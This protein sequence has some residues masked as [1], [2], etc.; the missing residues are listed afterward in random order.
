LQGIT[1]NNERF[2]G[3][4]FHVGT[5]RAPLSDRV[6]LKT[7]VLIALCAVWM[8]PGLVGRDPWKPD[9]AYSF[10]LIYHILQTGD[11]VVPTLGGEPFMEKPPLYYLTAAW[12][13]KS[14]SPVLPLHDGARLAS[15]FYMALTLLFLAG[16]ARELYGKGY[17][18]LAVVSFLGC[19]GLLLPAHQILTDIALLSGLAMGL[20]GMALSR[21]RSILGG[22]LLGTGAGIG[23]LSKGLLAPGVLGVTTLAM[24]L[25][26]SWRNRTYVLFLV[27]AFVAALPWALIWPVALYHRSPQLFTDWFWTNNFGR[28]LG[29]AGLGPAGDSLFYVRRLADITWPAFPF[30]L[31]TLWRVRLGSLVRPELQLPLAFFA[32]VFIVLSAAADARGL[33]A[34]P[35]MLPISL[36]AAVEMRSLPSPLNAALFWSAVILFSISALAVWLVWAAVH[37]N[38]PQSLAARMSAIQPAYR[39]EI[40]AFAIGM[41]MAITGAWLA[42]VAGVRHAW[43]RPI[44]AW[45]GGVAMLWAV[46]AILLLGWVN[47]GMSYKGM[48]S[49]MHA[50]MPAR[51]GCMASQ[52][53]GEPQRGMIEYYLGIRTFR[54]E[55]PR[56]QPCD[57]LLW[58]G[59]AR[60][61]V[62]EPGKEWK[63]LWQGSR[64]GDTKERFWLFV[65]SP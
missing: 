29:F 2:M 47:T 35:L 60:D 45:S 57:L 15:A 17:A 62:P 55:L 41:A 59:W 32:V 3:I 54:R 1:N 58:Q 42:L 5:A 53:L 61:Q 31:W 38:F 37:L 46:T 26:P 18:G 51:Y 34:L 28:F 22:L 19:F 64:P 13:A 23:F 9:E 63:L 12:F 20:F 48:F 65:R 4:A 30:A 39:P 52:G 36:L 33:Y 10:G 8:F 21:R 16:A 50:A 7:W 25:F 40:H 44:L 43:E 24:F 11:W 27:V 56:R 6:W 14:F 49:E